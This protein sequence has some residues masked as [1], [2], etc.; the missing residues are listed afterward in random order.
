M[1]KQY[2]GKDVHNWK[3]C[4]HDGKP[5]TYPKDYAQSDKRGKPATDF[6]GY[7]TAHAFAITH[8]GVAVR[9]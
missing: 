8:G 5:L 2:T 9:V 7:L 3:A 4:S 1:A 6:N